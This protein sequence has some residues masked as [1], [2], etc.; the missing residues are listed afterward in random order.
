MKSKPN[1]KILHWDNVEPIPRQKLI[2]MV[3]ENP[4]I[5][6]ILCMLTE[7]INKEFL[8]QVNTKNLKVVSTMSV[9]VDH[10]DVKACKELGIKVGYTPNVL[11]ETT[12]DLAVG[13]MQF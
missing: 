6:G 8:Q 2:T 11:T 7:Q 4:D 3:K 5:K 9:G 10:I 1:Y 13:N 12:A